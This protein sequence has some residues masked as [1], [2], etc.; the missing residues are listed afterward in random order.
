MFQAYTA[1]RDKIIE[2]LGLQDAVIMACEVHELNAITGMKCVM[3]P[4]EPEPV[5]REVARRYG[6]THVLL[7]NN[8]VTGDAQGNSL[9][10]GLRTIESNPHFQLVAGPAERVNKGYRFRLYKIVD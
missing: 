6:V 4:L 9:R 5:I 10:P 3:I 8:L 1:L 2:P 7:V